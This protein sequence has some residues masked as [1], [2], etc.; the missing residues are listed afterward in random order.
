MGSAV[1]W[2]LSIGFAFG[3]TA[4]FFLSR[5]FSYGSPAKLE[6]RGNVAKAVAIVLVTLLVYI[7]AMS[8]GFI[9]DDDQEIQAN[10]TLQTFQ[11]L[12]DNWTGKASADYF[13][14]KTTMLWAE[15]QIWGLNPHGYHVMNIVLHAICALLFWGVLRQL[16]VPGAWL[17]GLLFAV[18][19]VHVES[20]AW[21]SER[22]NTLSLLFYLLSIGAYLR[23]EDTENRRS[24][25]FALGYFLASLL[26]KTSVVMLPVVLVLCTWWRNGRLERRDLVRTIPFFALSAVLSGVTIWFQYGRAIGEEVIPIGGFWSRLAGAGMTVWWYLWKAIC[27]ANLTTIYPRWPINPPHLIQF[28]AGVMVVVM[29]AQLWFARKIMG[30]TPFFVFAYFVVTLFPVMGFIKMSY[31]RLT[32]VADHFQYLSDL[33]IVAG[34]AALIVQGL[35]KVNPSWRPAAMGGCAL[36]VFTL[37]AYSWERAGV[38]RTEK[39]LWEDALKKNDDS[40]QAHNHYGAV[41]YG[42][43]PPKIAQAMI[44]FKRAVELNPANPEVHNNYGLVLSAYQRWD[45]AIAEHRE[46][47]RIKKDHP[48]MR[49]N[50]AEVLMTTQHF[51]EAAEQ[52]RI[53]LEAE[54]NNPVFHVGYGVALFR[55]Q[56]F[57]EA[58]QEFETAL[59]IAPGLKQAAQNLEVVKRQIREGK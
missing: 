25:F 43:K 12:V 50:L 2:K 11:G 35:K 53:L 32:L 49:R 34:A 37:S 4:G 47:V 20:V 40:W 29:L 1:F 5:G 17:G 55:L 21:I 41:L 7:P 9:W 39:T 56:R 6:K 46:A 13:P 52:Y 33:S 27:P 15:Y 57:V 58:R 19:P 45:E 23:F 30:R 28:A 3:A 22:K 14:L 48:V 51:L 31:M 26:C 42:E 59:K 36:L 44:H 8:G 10:P 16:K 18:H 24:Y 38:H 54:P